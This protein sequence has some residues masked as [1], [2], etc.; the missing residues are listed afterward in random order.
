MDV[1]LWIIYPYITLTL[2][3]VGLFFRYST[4][5][6]GWTS[7]SSELLEKRQL[8]V[9]SPLFHWG[10]LAVFAGHIAGLLIPK[11]FYAALGVG[12]EAYHFV[13]VAG[14]RITGIAALIGL[15][16]LIVRRL[17]VKRVLLSTSTSDL[18]ALLALVVTVGLGM[19][20]TGVYDWLFGAYHYRSTIG[21][22]I[23]SILV[24]RPNIALMRGVPLIFK[25]HI[26][27]AFTFFA[28]SPWT[29][30]VHI[31]TFPLGYLRRAPIQYRIRDGLRTVRR[32]QGLDPDPE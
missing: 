30:L 25:L 17:S 32:K 26:A 15:F 24:L 23:R 13:A 19:G 22:W 4:D 12:Q 29:R 20:I 16:L 6:M 14:G 9:A 2:L 21:P 7:K 18:V 1:F 8:R 10:I 27:A 31:W 5:P 11:E 28:I 3:V